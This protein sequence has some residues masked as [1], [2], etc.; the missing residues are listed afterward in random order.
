MR[1]DP[2]EV[3]DNIQINWLS[4]RQNWKSPVENLF[5]VMNFYVFI[6]QR[7]WSCK[8]YVENNK[9]IVF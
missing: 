1:S 7:Y 5:T 2:R 6:Y 3:N 8:I 9:I 4:N